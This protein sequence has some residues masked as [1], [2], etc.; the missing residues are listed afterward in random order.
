MH[1]RRIVAQP[2]GEHRDPRDRHGQRERPDD[3]ERGDDAAI[4]WTRE[5]FDLR[6]WNV[7]PADE[8]ARLIQSGDR[9]RRDEREARDRQQV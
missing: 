1:Q 8:L 4:E 7:A 2:A 3:H 6:P 9:R 5:T